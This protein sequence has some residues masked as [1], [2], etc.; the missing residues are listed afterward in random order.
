MPFP[1]AIC[2]KDLP[3]CLAAL[4][5]SSFMLRIDAILVTSGVFCLGPNG[6]EASGVVSGVIAGVVS[7]M[8]CTVA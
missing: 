1:S 2:M 4:K 6:I 7:G 3:S 8:I 5:S